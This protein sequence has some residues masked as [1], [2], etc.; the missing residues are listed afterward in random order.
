MASVK[1][2][3]DKLI[4]WYA[5]NKPG[6]TFSIQVNVAYCTAQKIANFTDD[7]GRLHYRGHFLVSRNETPHCG[8]DGIKPKAKREAAT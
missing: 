3:L 2:D 5:T 8:P 6:E 1:E 4:D 7:D